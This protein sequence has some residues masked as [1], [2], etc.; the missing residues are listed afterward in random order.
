MNVK[1]K[2]YKSESEKRDSK[3]FE[4]RKK[5]KKRKNLEK[6]RNWYRPFSDLVVTESKMRLDNLCPDPRFVFFFEP[7]DDCPAS[8]LEG[9][10]SVVVDA[11]F[12]LWICL[13]VSRSA[14]CEYRNRRCEKK[15][16]IE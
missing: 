11:P 5:V 3:G 12:A 6:T 15:N 7:I 9:D 8:G 13:A 1:E 2:K 4:E 14:E 16:T 10:V